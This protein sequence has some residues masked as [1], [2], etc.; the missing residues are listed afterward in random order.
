MND[1]KW[2]AIACF[3]GSGL[4]FFFPTWNGFRESLTVGEGTIISTVFFVGGLI[5]LNL[6]HHR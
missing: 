4:S 1:K 5:L 2:A 3:V 6:P